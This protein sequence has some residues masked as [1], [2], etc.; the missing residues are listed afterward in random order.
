MPPTFKE[1]EFSTERRETGQ[2]PASTTTL[3]ADTG[4]KQQPVA[5]EVPVT[6]NGARTVDG[7]DKREPFSET[8]KTVL[9]F[10]NGAVIRLSSSVA[11]G[12]LLFLTNESTR[13]EVVCQVVK[14]KNY[15]NV[16]GY[17]ELE[18][19]EAVLG[20]WGMR[21]P[22]DR[23]GSAPR[24][25]APAPGAASSFPVSASPAI[26][27]PVVPKVELPAAS[28]TPGATTDKPAL[29]VPVA[30]VRDKVPKLAESKYVIPEP[31]A[32]QIPAASKM[33]VSPSKRPVA[34]VAP[35]PSTL[36]ASVD[37]EA[38]LNL[39]AA[40]SLPPVGAA[41]PS[42]P[43]PAIPE[44]SVNPAAP[45]SESALFDS[46]RATQAKASF[47]QPAKSAPAPMTA[48]V[49]NEPSPFKAK[50]SVPAVPP[51][52]IAPPSA[53]ANTQAL[54]QKTARLQEQLSGMVFS[55]E[56]EA[57]ATVSVQIP[58]MP[59][60]VIEKE[61]AENAA[62]AL[63]MSQTHAPE[64]APVQPVKPI[65]HATPVQLPKAVQPV[66]QHG[67]PVQAAA[68]VQ[69]VKPVQRAEPVGSVNSPLEDQ[70]LKIPAWLEPLARNVTAPS[71]TQEI[72]E[73]EKAKRLAEL[74]TEHP[75]VV[76][77]AEETIGAPEEEPITE[78]QLPSFGDELPPEEEESSLESESTSSGKGVLAGAIAAA[79]LLLVGGSWWY[80]QRSGGVHAGP[81]AASN[82]QASVASLP[83][84]NS[85]SQPP[86][87]P[88]SGVL[89]NTSAPSKSD[90]N[91][92]TILPAGEPVARARNSQP[93]SNPS[94]AGPAATISASAQPPVEQ[95]KKP[96]PGEIQLATPKT[97][98]IRP[99]RNAGEPEP[100]TP[101]NL[102]AQTV[103][104]TEV[105]N[106][107]LVVGNNQPSA[108][109]AEP[110][111]PVGGDVKPAKLITSV[112]PAY[113]SLA[114]SQRVS[115]N[116]VIDALIDVNG[117]VTTMKVV[118]GPTLLHQAAMDALKRWKYQPATLDGKPAPM[119]LT[120]T[121][122]FRLQ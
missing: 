55:G 101:L 114:K 8:T 47:L 36:S 18:F 93:E 31:S 85:P 27:Q 95:Q 79:I 112:P 83:V 119:H 87:Q 72:I 22:G 4:I 107:G 76:E 12:Q 56:P 63:E 24:P 90:R 80:M 89:T 35:L 42:A 67:K 43:V 16:S 77:I 52:P 82:A 58:H 57:H 38:P 105:L 6:V 1:D 64:S 73:H 96:N 9:V 121:I 88:N 69:P 102:D 113:P 15:R 78:V 92:L 120:V 109:A 51:P 23:I 41:V 28:V 60:A 54:K 122:Q 59:P 65:Q 19:T 86:A 2:R 45:A 118:S 115:G 68:P 91:T 33:E 84:A 10:G 108:P 21:F 111:L 20:F 71:S 99:A 32:A 50:P 66:V 46:P 117:H 70:E 110:A 103:P 116:V 104:G 100:G 25:A 49:Q 5:L 106:A 62:K 17:V 61:L 29:P 11:S 34:P 40:T 74:P 94:N 98:P 30:V 39:S 7:S 44:F 81:A 26:P 48:T 37:G 97:S 53:S 13:K 75:E 14:S 3:S